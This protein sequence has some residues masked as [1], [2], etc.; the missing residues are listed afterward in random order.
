MNFLNSFKFQYFPR[1]YVSSFDEDGS[2][3][4]WENSQETASY[5]LPGNDQKLLPK[6]N[7]PKETLS[8]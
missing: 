1:I 3:I 5:L 6:S 7:D 2:G 4:L 8:A